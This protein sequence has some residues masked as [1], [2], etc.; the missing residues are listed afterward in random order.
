MAR[1]LLSYHTEVLEKISTADARTFRKELRKAFRRLV[2]T[3]RE[4]LKR[5]FRD[6]CACRVGERPTVLPARVNGQLK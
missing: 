5:W 1:D 4:K 3:D 6:S 2:P